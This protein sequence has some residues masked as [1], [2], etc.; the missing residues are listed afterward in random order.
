[1]GWVKGGD[2]NPIEFFD[3]GVVLILAQ[4]LISPALGTEGVSPTNEQ[5]LVANLQNHPDVIVTLLL[6]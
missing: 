5:R 2:G 6:K 4:I 3:E 1:V